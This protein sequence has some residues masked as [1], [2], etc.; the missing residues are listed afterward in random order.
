LSTNIPGMNVGS[1]FPEL[2]IPTEEINFFQQM[3]NPRLL[4]K[5]EYFVASGTHCNQIAFIDSGILC[6]FKTKGRKKIILSC[7]TENQFVSVF[8][9]FLTGEVSTL[10]IQAL[11]PTCLT[12]VSNHLFHQLCERD[13][14]WTQF[15]LKVLAGKTT[16][17][18]EIEKRIRND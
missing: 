15:W 16:E 7:Y 17:A 2:A 1:I 4:R 10:T 12:V 6:S 11:E 3:V 5:D 8:T 9:S 13:I 14:C 18:I